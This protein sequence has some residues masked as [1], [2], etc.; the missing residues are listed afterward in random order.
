MTYRK[1]RR[2]TLATGVRGVDRMW[3]EVT[4]PNILRLRWRELRGRR[5][6]RQARLKYRIVRR[7]R[8]GSQLITRA[9]V[10]DIAWRPRVGQRV[11]GLRFKIEIVPV[12]VICAP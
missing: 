11:V 9:G 3:G 12:Q 4:E 2:R 8:L 7:G 5:V 1:E 6:G 10:G